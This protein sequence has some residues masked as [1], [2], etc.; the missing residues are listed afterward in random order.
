MESLPAILIGGPPHSGKSV[1]LY[2]L[3]QALRAAGVEHYALRA[4]PDGEGDWANEAGPSLVRAIRIKGGWTTEWVDTMCRDVER[5]HLPLLVD[6]G[7][8][9][10]LDQERIFDECTAAVLLTVDQK[11]H[12]EWMERIQSHGLPL[13]A[14]LRSELN[15]AEALLA[16]SLVVKGIITGLERGASAAGPTFD[17]LVAALTEHFVPDGGSYRARHLAAA[18]VELAIDLDRLAVTLEF[19]APGD[20]I[21]WEPEQL[22][23]LLDYLPAGTPLA[24]YG[25]GTN[26]VQAALACLAHPADYYSFDVRLGWALAHRLPLV[27]R[28]DERS[29]RYQVTEADEW[30]LLHV[31]L[32]TAYFDYSEMA[33]SEALAL[34]NDKGIVLSG[35]IPYWLTTSLAR[36]YLDAP[37]LAIY[38]PP[39]GGA[40]VVY[41]QEEER[42]GDLISLRY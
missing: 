17:A 18:P 27:A 42:I 15:G 36:T 39:L 3:S 23:P 16:T 30:R 21:F 9:P 32:T 13:L 41:S 11:T 20:E 40:V 2:S 29:L 35:K 19:A 38:Q 34:P 31:E 8:K 28:P 7:G 33:E 26:W 10:T 22:S 14:D 37:W 6:M 5:R 24:A 25:R 1:L 4:C 12:S